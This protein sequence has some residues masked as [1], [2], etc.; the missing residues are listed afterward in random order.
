MTVS[1]ADSRHS[2]QMAALGTI[3]AAKHIINLTP[4]ISMIIPN[5][6]DLKYGIIYVYHD[7][8]RKN[9]LRMGSGIIEKIAHPFEVEWIEDSER[10]HDYTS[11]IARRFNVGNIGQCATVSLRLSDTNP[12]GVQFDALEEFRKKLFEV[13]DMDSGDIFI[14][15]DDFTPTI[16]SRFNENE[17]DCYQMGFDDFCL[18][19][20]APQDKTNVESTPRCIAKKA[21][22]WLK[23]HS[24]N[25]TGTEQQCLRIEE[26][27]IDLLEAEESREV[28]RIE[29]E[30]KRALERIRRDIINYVAQYHDDPK[31]LMEELLRGKIIV[32]QPG[33][34]LVNGD[35]KIV[36]PDYDELEIE[37]PA[38]CRTL[39]ILF[40][41][42]R[43]QGSNGIV[44]KTIDEYRDEILDIYGMVK[45]GAN[46]RRVKL[47]VDNLCDPFSD[48]LNQTI[49]RINR[50]IRN[51]ITDKELARD[52]R[53]T[54]G[55][56][57]EY[58]I[59]LD[60]QYLEL[61][62]AVTGE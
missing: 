6:Q 12:R 26:P 2:C 19:S 45:P 47:S 20:A 58:G 11:L 3:F 34:I 1:R 23:G 32:G 49:S 15:E 5:H 29:R 54:G 18:P 60:P 36:L 8:E 61:P 50:C 7:P 53:I 13:S 35:M 4:S 24:F 51:V 30:R 42:L 57:K 39:Y 41:K 59:L 16:F 27:D 14:D 22:R 52:Y 46:E 44:L 38:M 28:A 37:M 48:S 21:S 55:R 10:G 40:M 56:G 62:R 31:T 43:K 25:T 9:D 33:R 17:D